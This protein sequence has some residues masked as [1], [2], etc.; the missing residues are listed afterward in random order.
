MVF[1]LSLS[2][3]SMWLAAMTLILLVTSELLYSLPEYSSRVVI[4]KKLLR[5]VAL[6]CGIGFLATI[7][8]LYS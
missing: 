6:G 1:P 5:L 3:V 7:A 8:L 2:E 4:D